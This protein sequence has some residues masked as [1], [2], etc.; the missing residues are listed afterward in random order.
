M[1]WRSQKR[2]RFTIR[3]FVSCLNRCSQQNFRRSLM[4]LGRPETLNRG[5]VY[6][7]FTLSTLKSQIAWRRVC[8]LLQ[9]SPLFH[10][11]VYW[12]KNIYQNNSNRFVFVLGCELEICSNIFQDSLY[13]FRVVSLMDSKTDTAKTV[14]MLLEL[15]GAST[16]T[17]HEFMKHP[18]SVI[19]IYVEYNFLTMP[20]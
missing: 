5:A 9:L 20:C 11:W 16:H 7:W 15:K 17:L 10:I 12:R 6:R 13:V 3:R 18:T 1:M 8:I 2:F 4:S 14:N 19:D